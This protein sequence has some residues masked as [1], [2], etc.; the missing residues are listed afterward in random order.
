MDNK[1]HIDYETGTHGRFLEFT[2]N[3]LLAGDAIHQD[4]PFYIDGTSHLTDN[5]AG[6]NYSRHQVFQAAHWHHQG[7]PPSS[8]IISIQCNA[9][10]RLFVMTHGYLR[11]GPPEKDDYYLHRNTFY[12]LNNTPYVGLIKYLGDR[13]GVFLSENQP[14]CPRNILRQYYQEMFI[15]WFLG[16]HEH[17]SP[18]NYRMDQQVYI[19]PFNSF[20]NT[21][22]FKTQLENIRIFFAL[23]YSDFDVTQ[24]HRVFLS[25][26][27]FTGYKKQCQDIV[28]SVIKNQPCSI[29]NLS[30]FQESYINALLAIHYGCD[31]I[32]Q[33]DQ[34]PTDSVKLRSALIDIQKRRHQSSR[35]L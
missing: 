6:S 18:G 24:L 13:H 23:T 3:K 9:D 35:D 8:Q 15:G 29:A 25:H 12:K 10:D 19:F 1:I 11:S 14:H 34:Y 31:I 7:S 20:Y 21:D 5:S 2:L 27:F 28:E 4:H 30:L 33:D 17:S 26:M 16:R 22:Q 32:L